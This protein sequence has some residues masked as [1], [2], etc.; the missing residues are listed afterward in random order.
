MKKVMMLAAVL[1]FGG[2]SACGGGDTATTNP[3]LT[4]P[5]NTASVTAT[6]VGKNITVTWIAVSGATNYK[7]DRKTGSGAYSELASVS[8]TTYTDT[9]LA[10][11]TYTYRVRSS[12]SAGAASGVESTTVTITTPT[13][14]APNNPAS[15]TAVLGTGGIT[16]NWAIVVGATSYTLERQVGSGAFT[17][18]TTTTGTS[19]VDAT[20]SPGT[21]VYRVKAINSSGSSSGITTS[22]VTVSVAPTNESLKRAKEFIGTWVMTYRI[23]STFSD[24]LKFNRV[25]EST[26]RPGEYFAAGKDQLGNIIVAWY[27]FD[28]NKYVIGGG[29]DSLPIFYEFSSIAS[30]GSVSGVVWFVLNNGFSDNYTMA[31]RRISTAIPALSV[32][33]LN[34]ND[35]SSAQKIYSSLR[36]R[37]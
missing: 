12:N 15:I 4:I 36:S 27:S 3:G 8:E 23:I 24:T 11:G 18:V 10:D 29:S 5:I 31:G 35:V 7:V 22:P 28:Y 25:L 13:T 2:L 34:L 20:P 16:V 6:A 21:Y 19:Y 9:N 26:S 37:H 33:P 14:T 17:S 30:D 32:S 1:A